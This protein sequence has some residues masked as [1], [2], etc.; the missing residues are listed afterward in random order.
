MVSSM[1]TRLLVPEDWTL[2]S[3]SHSLGGRL[4]LEPTTTLHRYHLDSFDWR[5]YR[6]GS[7]LTLESSGPRRA[8]HW[9]SGEQEAPYV[10]PT[11]EDIRFPWDLPP[12]F[13]RGALEEILELRALIP[14][15]TSRVEQ[16]LGRLIDSEGNLAVRLCNERVL[17]LDHT[18]SPSPDLRNAI[19][20]QALTGH[21]SVYRELLNAL[22]EAGAVDD[23]VDDLTAAAAAVGRRPGD[24]HS[25]P[26]LEL[27]PEDPSCQALRQILGQLLSTLRANVDGVLADV[28]VEFLHDLRVA[29]RRTR[30]A[31]AQIKGVLPSEAVERFTPEFKWLGTVTGPCRD[32]DVYL[33]E[34]EGFRK[35][36][37]D[38]SGVLDPL[39]ELIERARQQA[40]LAVCSALESQRFRRLLDDWAEFLESPLSGDGDTPNAGLPISNVADGR[41]LKAY[42]RMVKRGS[43]LGGDPPAEA[44]HR[45]RIDAKKLR[46][47][48]EFFAALYPKKTISRLVRELKQLQDILGGFNDMEVQQDRL[49]KFAE[50]L[51]A[52][53]DA[54][55]ETLLAMGRL[56][57]AMATRQEEH[58]LAFSDSF[59]QFAN[60]DSQRLYRK[61]FGGG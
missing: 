6:T 2:E 34:M 36:L 52:G 12:G 21:E 31:L 19:H 38:E 61:L 46:Y 11:V 4:Q 42:R 29:T 50:E 45:L 26:D 57:A 58:R 43:K 59:A 25:K 16:Q 47:L 32:L 33:I 14:V 53:E 39:R 60:D 35:Q 3:L 17:P 10:L 55:A 1:Q 49:A 5:L 18:G 37:K 8:L 13:L 40:H 30:S 20:L 51:V 56:A 22:H 23:A 48:L 7:R 15:G 44:L 54:H 27:K 9:S 28:D 24:Y 41:I